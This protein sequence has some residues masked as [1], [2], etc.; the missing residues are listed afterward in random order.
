[1]KT[2]PELVAKL[3]FSSSQLRYFE[4]QCL[5]EPNDEMHDIVIKWQVKVDEVLCFM[6]ME[7]FIPLKTLIETIKLDDYAQTNTT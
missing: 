3:I 2:T 4:Q 7:E 5:I 1:M 6:G